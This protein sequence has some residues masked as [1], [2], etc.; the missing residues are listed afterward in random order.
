MPKLFVI[1]SAVT[2]AQPTAAYNVKTHGAKGDG[3]TL[4]TTAINR[5]IEAA[6][7]AG[8]G[9]VYF[10]PGTYVAG[11][12]HLESNITLYLEQGSIIEASSDPI[13]YEEAEPNAWTQYQDFGHS[14]FHNSLIWGE[15]VHDVAIIGH[16]T[17]YGKG[18][19]RYDEYRPEL[20]ERGY[21][22]CIR[23]R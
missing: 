2:F 21:A 17:I 19:T 20:H 22:A 10:P 13:A 1:F 4:D 23:A 5:A 12:I 15:D 3:K 18:L 6:D 7:A 14:H 16:G 9:T 8:G 11:S